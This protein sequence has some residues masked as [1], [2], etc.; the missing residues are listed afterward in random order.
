MNPL[1]REKKIQETGRADRILTCPFIDMFG[2]QLINKNIREVNL[3]GRLMADLEIEAYKK[4]GHDGVSVGPGLYG[5][6]EAMGVVLDLPEKSYPYVT[7]YMEVDYENIDNLP[8][9]NAKKDGRLPIFLEGVKILIDEVSH[10]VGVGSSV[11][12]PFSTA[13][14][15]IG[16][17]KFLKDIRKNPEGIH[18]LLARVTKSVLAYMDAVMDL[19]IVPSMPDPVASGTLISTKTFKEF[20]LPYLEICVEHIRKRMGRGPAL[21]ICGTTKKHWHEIKKLNLSALSLDNIDDIGEAC[22]VLGDKFC[23]IGNVDP[24]KVMLM[25]TRESIHKEVKECIEKAYD[26]PKGFVLATGCDI[27]INASVE[28]VEYFM[29]AARLYSR[30]KE[31]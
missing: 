31:K 6:P 21:H 5:V 14:T 16:T 12:G 11:A 22:E 8:I 15:V 28:N 18:K 7:K 4:F 23:I 13:A 30:F 17:E 19:G 9:C 2:A 29:E 20:A 1:E 25:G 27:P 10:E 24:V 3:S 26:N